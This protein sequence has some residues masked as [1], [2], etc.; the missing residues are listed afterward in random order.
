MEQ[1]EGIL[2]EIGF[3][4]NEAKVYLALLDLGS[5]TIQNIYK[6]IVNKLIKSSDTR[7]GVATILLI[8]SP[9]LKSFCHKRNYEKYYNAKAE[10]N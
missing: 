6:K 3:S 4:K 9:R 2:E 1:D 10:N 8:D 7:G 5:T